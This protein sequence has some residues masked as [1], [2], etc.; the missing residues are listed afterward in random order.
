[1]A[2]PNRLFDFVEVSE[3]FA[4]ICARL[5]CEFFVLVFVDVLDVNEENVRHAH[6]FFEFLKPFAFFAEWS[7]RRVN[8]GVYGA[9]FCFCEQF[10][11]KINLRKRFSARNGDAALLAPKV[12]AIFGFVK[13]FVR[14]VELSARHFPGVGIVAVQTAERAARKENDEARTWPVRAAE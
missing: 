5:S 13:Q 4:H 14:R 2:N 9:F 11:Q 12:T 7:S 8:T 3:H 6:E 1:M 10:E